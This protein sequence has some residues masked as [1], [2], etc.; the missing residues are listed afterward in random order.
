MRNYC[1]F[2]REG[3]FVKGKINSLSLQLLFD[4]CCIIVF[5]YTVTLTH[6]RCNL[7]KFTQINYNKITIQLKQVNKTENYAHLKVLFSGSTRGH[8]MLHDQDI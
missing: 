8:Q 1:K 2:Y 6:S 4:Y 7:P 5:S 3:H